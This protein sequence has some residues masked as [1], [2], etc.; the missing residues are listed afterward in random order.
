[1]SANGLPE[2]PTHEGHA[3]WVRTCHWIMA[4]SVLTLAVSGFYILMV[5]PRLYWG[6]VGN[7]L[8]PAW[9]ELPISA[10]H[11]PAGW[12][13]TVTFD[14]VPGAPISANRTYP[15]FNENGW[16]R[17]L[18][19]L[20]GWFLVSAGALYCLIGALTGHIARDL[21]PRGPMLAALRRELARR[22]RSGTQSAAAAGQYGLL[23][24]CAYVGVA[25]V[26]LPLM[27]LAGLAMS[28]RVAA[29]WPSLLDVFGGYQS[30]RTLH[31]IGFA[32]LI[33]FVIVHVAMVIRAGAG[34]MLRAMIVGQ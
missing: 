27:V 32:A 16:A 2:P 7:D 28:P 8:T 22:R 6:E 13:Q 18:H 24:R 11:Q 17:S 1:M 5:H 4:A 12:Q 26:V 33:V 30:A 3:L 15:T 21:A 10:N 25:F 23:Q 29:A 19:F 20:A 31:F 9:L 14:A 34:R